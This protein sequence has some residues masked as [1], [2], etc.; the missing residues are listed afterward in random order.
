MIF[1]NL[2]FQKCFRINTDSIPL[3]DENQNKSYLSHVNLLAFLPFLFSSTFTTLQ[4][5]FS[6]LSLI[7]MEQ[8]TFELQHSL[9]WQSNFEELTCPDLQSGISMKSVQ[10]HPFHSAG[11][12]PKAVI[13]CFWYDYSFSWEALPCWVSTCWFQLPVIK[14]P[15]CSLENLLK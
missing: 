13:Q 7:V 3:S 5:S 2:I 4:S 1:F 8:I 15:Q 10:T 11:I 9:P 12:I 6:Q 14:W